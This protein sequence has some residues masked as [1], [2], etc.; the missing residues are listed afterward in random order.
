MLGGPGGI[1]GY[2]HAAPKG[3]FASSLLPRR[4]VQDAYREQRPCGASSVARSAIKR[5]LRQ[6]TVYPLRKV[7]ASNPA[8]YQIIRPSF[9]VLKEVSDLPYA[10][11]KLGRET[12]A[13]VSVKLRCFEVLALPTNV[14]FLHWRR[15]AASG[16]PQW[17]TENQL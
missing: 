15:C 11:S 16:T 9:S 8:R 2:K 10:P 14:V 13:R 7:S 3:A 5:P 17:R 12:A 6:A 4:R 1:C